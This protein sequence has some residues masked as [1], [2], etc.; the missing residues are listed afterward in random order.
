MT[1]FGRAEVKE[2]ELEVLAEIRS[3]N[4]RFLDIQVRLPKQFFH[5]EHEVKALVK[6]FALRGRINVFVNTKILADDE[7]NGLTI[8]DESVNNYIR[9]AK[10]LKEKYNI[11]GKL[12]LDHL[13]TFTDIFT[14]DDDSQLKE[15]L[16][17]AVKLTLV[18][19]LEN[20]QQMRQEEGSELAAD[21][22]N[23]IKILEQ[24]VALI[25]KMSA[26]RYG[27]ELVKLKQRVREIIEDENIEETR[28]ETEIALMMS[29]LDVTEEC[30]RFKSHNK[31]FLSSLES[32][33]AAGR[34]LNFLLQEM[35]REANTIGSKANHADI[36]H[37]VVGIK[38]EIEK[39]REQVQN[40]E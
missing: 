30:V 13:L 27:D 1:G 23:R 31:L 32:K 39:I 28:L 16:W 11:E 21:L 29:R 26:E 7:I 18:K 20:F 19:A 17:K 4:N 22:I 12:S 35:T 33:E 6:K 9:L 37:L 14:Y 2:R 24:K 36:S 8:N 10:I 15:K 40:I 3:V 5:L 38:E 34:K 25:E